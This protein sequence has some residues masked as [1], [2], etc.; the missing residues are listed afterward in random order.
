[1]RVTKADLADIVDDAINGY[2]HDGNPNKWSLARNLVLME[3]FS[4]HAIRG[5]VTSKYPGC[6]LAS[7]E[8]NVRVTGR[9]VRILKRM[10]CDVHSGNMFREFENDPGS[11]QQATHKSQQ[12]RALW[13]TWVALMLREGAV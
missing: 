7:A 1:M 8:A 10:G 12:A 4:C 5:A 11:T 13:L 9:L 3:R 6:S 2:L